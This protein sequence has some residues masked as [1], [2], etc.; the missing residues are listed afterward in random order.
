LPLPVPDTPLASRFAART[1]LIG[2]AA[3]APE[4]RAQAAEVQALIGKH[5]EFLGGRAALVAAG[6]FVETGSIQAP[7]GL[8]HYR[9]YVRRRPFAFRQEVSRGD[10]APLLVRITDGRHAW[11]PL[12]GGKGELLAGGEARITLEAAFFDGMRYVEPEELAGRAGLG[13]LITLPRPGGLPP[14]I[15]GGFVVQALA[16]AAPGGATIQLHFDVGDARLHGLVN[17]DESPQRY[18]RYADWRQFGPLRLPKVR[19]EGVVGEAPVRVE[20]EELRFVNADTALFAG[21]PVAALPRTLVAS[22]LELLPH[23]IPGAAQFLLPRVGLDARAAVAALLDTGAAQTYVAAGV[24]ERAGLPALSPMHTH[25]NAGV[26]SAT[27]CWLDSLRIGDW[28]LLQLDVGAVEF[29]QILQ[30]GD[31]A[32]PAVVLGG[33][34]FSAGP[35]LDL[36]RGRLLLRGAPVTPLAEL[37]AAP[38]KVITLP[39]H[40]DHGRAPLTLVVSI[41]GAAVTAVFDTGMHVP[42]RLTATGLAR[43]GLPVAVAEWRLR[44]AMPMGMSGAGGRGIT[45][46]LVQIEA[47]RFGTVVLERPWVLLAIG[48][49]NESAPYEAALGGGALL[50]CARVGIDLSRNLLELEA[51]GRVRMDGEQWHVPP[52]GQFLGL[53]TGPGDPGALT[54]PGSLPVVVEVAPDSPASAAGIAAGDRIVAIDGESC[55]GLEPRRWNEKLWV[56]EGNRIELRIRKRSGEDVRIVLP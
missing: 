13:P 37:A 50:A 29:P 2:L 41:G 43:L 10:G 7:G 36:E 23:A 38:A 9:A 51:G 28:R 47:L 20:L 22:T 56:R 3:L 24:A 17:A 49:A 18:V 21:N 35:V 27:R 32:Q 12:P 5:L 14:E 4:L 46:L 42:L 8:L 30:L 53:L 6:D 44:G 54:E 26:A 15:R 40:R 25:G 34:L 52:A 11:R 31:D 45:D 55:A 19:Y 48:E 39:L 1:L 33:D 16:Y